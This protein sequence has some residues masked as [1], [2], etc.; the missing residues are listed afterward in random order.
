[1]KSD[2]SSVK[3]GA[4][5][6]TRMGAGAEF[7]TIRAMVGRWGAR[8]SGIGD[9][10]A[11]LAARAGGALVASTDTSVEG[12]HFRREWLAPEEIGYRAAAAALSDL[13][14]MGAV[15]LGLLAAM[16][17]PPAWL[18]ELPA[19]SDGVGE[20]AEVAGTVVIGG[21]ISQGRDLSLTITVLGTSQRIL[22]R[23]RAQAGDIVYVTGR[24]GGPLAALRELTRR[25]AP[26]REARERF[27]HPVPRINEAVWLA[28]HGASAAIDISDGLASELGHLSAASGVRIQIELENVPV[29]PG[30]SAIDATASGEEYELLITAPSEIDVREFW[31]KFNLELSRIGTVFEGEGVA[32]TLNGDA[33]SPPPGYLHFR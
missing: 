18:A 5:S 9:D 28:E 10:A 3:S 1:M 20:A 24:L 2:D 29:M 21:D 7:D 26:S 19:I 31:A 22:H 14:A 23:S 17:I 13:A 12:V 11:V 32:M 6:E 8:A 4:P 15:P 30:L 27:A 16:T 33:I 25:R